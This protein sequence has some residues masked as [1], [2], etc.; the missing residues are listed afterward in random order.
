MSSG[1]GEEFDLIVIGG[2]PA[3]ST[4]S[5][6]VA[7]QEHKVLLLERERFPRYQIGE[8]LLPST[9][10]GICVMLGVSEDLKKASFMIKKGGTFRGRKGVE[11]RECNLVKDFLRGADGRVIGVTVAQPDGSECEL[12]ARYVADASGNESRLATKVGERIHSKFFKNVA[13]F[14]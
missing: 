2:G 11:I 4:V 5:S 12:K 8:S 1:K 14:C 7:M 3:G 9:I 10:H 13:L 6:F